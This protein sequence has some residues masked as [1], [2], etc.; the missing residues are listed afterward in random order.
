MGKGSEDRA[1]TMAIK[2]FKVT[3]GLLFLALNGYLL[4]R[5]STAYADGQVRGE[6]LQK[7]KEE[8]KKEG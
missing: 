3:G 8:R 7:E 1:I 2:A 4:Y 6:I 5:F